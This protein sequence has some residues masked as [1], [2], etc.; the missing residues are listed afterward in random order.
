MIGA[1]TGVR[2]AQK[3]IIVNIVGVYGTNTVSMLVGPTPCDF[4]QEKIDE[5]IGAALRKFAEKN[6]KHNIL[7]WQHI[8]LYAECN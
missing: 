7:F 3:S 5:C 1:M 6:P 8:E 4:T 2:V